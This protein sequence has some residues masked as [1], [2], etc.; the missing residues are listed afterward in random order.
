MSLRKYPATTDVDSLKPTPGPN[1]RNVGGNSQFITELPDFSKPKRYSIAPESQPTPE[2][3]DAW[4]SHKLS[5]G[6]TKAMSGKWSLLA[7]APLRPMLEELG[8]GMPA[9]AEY[10]RTKQQ[11]DALR[12]EWHAKAATVSDA[13]L[14]YRS[15]NRAEKPGSWRSCMRAP[16][17][18]MS[19][20]AP[21]NRSSPR[22]TPQ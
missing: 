16:S 10:P 21:T 20:P 6:L 2:Q 8:K 1:V 17:R 4:L 19:P 12:N 7:A 15:H 22:T 18:R 14:S 5:D 11:M 13:W 9:A 3:K